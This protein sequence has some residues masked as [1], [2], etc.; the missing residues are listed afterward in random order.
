MPS[1]T[2]LLEELAA[3]A[4]PEP[5]VAPESA[6]GLYLLSDRIERLDLGQDNGVHDRR[7]FLRESGRWSQAVLTP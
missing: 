4:L 3:V 6:R 2:A 7:L 5:L 1:R